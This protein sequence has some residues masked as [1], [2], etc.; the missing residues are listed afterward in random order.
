MF[1]TYALFGNLKTSFFRRTP[2]YLQWGIRYYSSDFETIQY[3]FGSS[4]LGARPSI[5]YR[6]NDRLQADIQASLNT[7]SIH[8]SFLLKVQRP[9][10]NAVSNKS[11]GAMLVSSSD[12]RWSSNNRF[13]AQLRIER[14]ETSKTKV[15]AQGK[16]TKKTKQKGKRKSNMNENELTLRKRTLICRLGAFP[17]RGENKNETK[18]LTLLFH[19]YVRVVDMCWPPHQLNDA[20]KSEGT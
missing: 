7:Q 4:R 6:H 15:R 11:F 10:K 2:M 20:T 8:A 5:N 13:R 18:Q 1:Q 9:A 12:T 16:Q 14:K 17:R 19:R 3:E